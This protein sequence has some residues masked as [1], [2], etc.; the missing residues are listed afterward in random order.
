MSKSAKKRRSDRRRELKRSAKA[1]KR[2]LYAS[3]SGTGRRAKR[4]KRSSGPTAQKGNH[5]MSNCG[6]VGC[7]KCFPQFRRCPQNAV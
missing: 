3:Y 2:A 6:N 5:A 1:A 4:V 7:S